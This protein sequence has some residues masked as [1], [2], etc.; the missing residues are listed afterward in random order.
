MNLA[1]LLETFMHGTLEEYEEAE[2]LLGE[3]DEDA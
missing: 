2:R 1:L 3:L